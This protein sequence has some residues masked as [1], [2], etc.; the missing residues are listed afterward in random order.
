MVANPDRHAR[1]H[2]EHAPQMPGLRIPLQK[3][4]RQLQ[5]FF[6]L[7]GGEKRRHG[8][9]F[10]RLVDVVEQ[11]VVRTV[12]L[13]QSRIDFLSRCRNAD[14]QKRDREIEEAAPYGAIGQ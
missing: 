11:R 7:L 8:L 4:F 5:T 14:Q 9:A 2:P 10:I 3:V 1:R 6:R 12:R 13:V